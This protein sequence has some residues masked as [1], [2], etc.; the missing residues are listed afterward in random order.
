MSGLVGVLGGLNSELKEEGCLC[1]SSNSS[2]CYGVAPPACTQCVL[3]RL[4]HTTA[5]TR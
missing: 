1:I 2:W 5:K 4:S 3:S